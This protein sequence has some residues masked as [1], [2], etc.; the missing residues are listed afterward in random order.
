MNENDSIAPQPETINAS[1]VEVKEDLCADD[2]AIAPEL[3]E[4]AAETTTPAKSSTL[5]EF[6]GARAALPQWRKDLSERVREI[7]ER[8]ARDAAFEAEEA[9]RRRLEQPAAAPSAAPLGLVP[10]RETPAVNPLVA[11][12]LR[13]IERAQQPSQPMP[14]ARGNMGGGAAAAATARVA[15]EEQLQ[16]ETGFEPAL[17]SGAV[18]ATH[19]LTESKPS[20][21]PVEVAREHNLVVVP[22]AVPKEEKKPEPRRIFEGVVDDSVAS[23]LE[24][25]ILPAPS[26]LLYDDRASTSRRFTANLIDLLVVAFASSPFA[27]IIELTNGNWIDPRVSAS[28]GGIILVVMFLYFAAST[29]LTGRTWGMSLFSL[30]AVD[31]NTGLHPTTKQS[32]GRA[33]LYILSLATACLGILYALFDAEGRTAHDILTG[34]TVVKE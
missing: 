2:E 6:P 1:A 31:V 8:R 20:E 15:E 9:R 17:A 16:E 12:A 4:D 32:I 29:A 10:Q 23:R 28:M 18:S 7:Q 13:R 14:R 25:E 22:P 24:A 34:T 33:I 5:I 19:L 21:K 3:K 30:R 27:A 26:E 11:K